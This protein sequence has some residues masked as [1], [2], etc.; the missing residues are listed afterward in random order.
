MTTIPLARRIFL[1]LAAA[2]GLFLLY[3]SYEYQLLSDHGQA[4]PNKCSMTY[5]YPSYHEIEMDDITSYAGKYSL[6]YYRDEKFGRAG[7]CFL[8]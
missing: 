5:M 8:T 4:E 6:Y 2:V 1:A 7:V 3:A